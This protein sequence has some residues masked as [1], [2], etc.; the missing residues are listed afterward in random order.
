MQWEAAALLPVR[1]MAFFDLGVASVQTIRVK[2]RVYHTM[3]EVER[4]TTNFYQAS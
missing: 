2:Y 4:C 1:N 3:H